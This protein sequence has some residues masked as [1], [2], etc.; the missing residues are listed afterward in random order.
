M[1]S[2]FAFFYPLEKKISE[3]NECSDQSTNNF[4]FKNN[5]KVKCDFEKVDDKVDNMKQF[6]ERA[7][8]LNNIES[9][10]ALVPIK[11]TQAQCDS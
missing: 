3:A 6:G 11:S 5:L 1:L 4:F 9:I 2:S 10:P 8:R 7:K